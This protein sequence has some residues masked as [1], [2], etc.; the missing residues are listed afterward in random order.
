MM[1]MIIAIS[2]GPFIFFV[3]VVISGNHTR[4][5]I[6]S[7]CT[8][9][10]NIIDVM[11]LMRSTQFVKSRLIGRKHMDDVRTSQVLWVYWYAI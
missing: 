10:Y 9:N 1:M 5:I 8:L 7:R 4:G 3:V 2:V 6:K 11:P